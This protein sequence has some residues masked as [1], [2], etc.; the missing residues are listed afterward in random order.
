MLKMNEVGPQHYRDALARFQ[1]DQKQPATG[2]ADDTTISALGVG[3]A[4][5]N[6]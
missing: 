5:N 3:A 6:K 1:L 2:D 4:S